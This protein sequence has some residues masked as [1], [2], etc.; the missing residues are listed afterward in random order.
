MTMKITKAFSILLA[1]CAIGIPGPAGA[2][3]SSR[4][5]KVHLAQANNDTPYAF[6]R[7]KFNPGELADPWAV[8]FFDDHGKE[9]PYFVW[10]ATTWRV[11]REGRPDWGKR[12]ALLNHG[13][14]DAPSVVDARAR[15]LQ[16]AKK[17][18]PELG[19]KLEAQEQAAQKAPDSVCAAMYLLRYRVPAFGKERLTL[20]IFADRQVEPKRRVWKGETVGDR[21]TVKQGTL[22]FRDLPDRLG[23]SLGGKEIFR[24]AGFRAGGHSETTSH[25]DPSRP[26][27]VETTEG[28]ITS[29]SITVRTAGRQGGVMDWQCRYW[30]FPEGGF[31]AL[32]GFGVGDTAGYVGGPQK[33]SLW[34]TEGGFTQRRAPLWDTPWWVHQAGERGFVATHLFQATPLTIGFGNN[35]FAVNAE[36][37]DKAPKIEADGPRLALSWSHRI[38]DPAIA[39]VMVPMPLRRP[40][41]PPPKEL[42]KPASWQPKT[43]W[44]YR[45]YACG[46]GDA[47][48]GPWVGAGA[49]AP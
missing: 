43:D 41:D 20:R 9:V 42:P 31:V 48:G 11:A 27:V 39:R 8:R 40:K 36:G 32:E 15:K 2:A 4:E 1:V 49:S 22:E 5:L 25:A 28:I 47:A 6:V 38:D 37:P 33:L 29:L 24:H 18:S 30:L 16:W 26:F 17:N 34:Q 44:L 46:L 13:P 12:Y 10:D 45:Q 3:E 19:A 23:V 14:G 21:V 35:P 7:A